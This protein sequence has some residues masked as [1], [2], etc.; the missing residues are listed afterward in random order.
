LRALGQTTK[1]AR[2]TV[3][4]VRERIAHLREKTKEASNAKSYDFEQRLADIKAKELSLRA[5][6]KQQKK[7]ER[8]KARVELVKDSATLQDEN[9]MM[10]T[11]GFSGFGSTKK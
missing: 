4:Q 9:D 5:E 7:M 8:E 10:Q 2:S 11:L 6:K 1:I 3:Q